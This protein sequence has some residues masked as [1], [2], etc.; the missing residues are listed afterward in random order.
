MAQKRKIEIFS[1]GC[2]ACDETVQTVNDIA[3][4]SCEVQVL[5][6][7]REDVA[8]QAKEYGIK[9]VPAVVIDGKLAGCCAGRGIDEATLKASGIGSPL[10]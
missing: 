4:P 5:D 2:P 9:S 3:C 10:L 7:H 1:A 8:A 6:M